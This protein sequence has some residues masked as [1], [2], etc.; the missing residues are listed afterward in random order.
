MKISPTISINKNYHSHQW[1]LASKCKW[2]LP[3]L[4]SSR[5]CHPQ[6]D[7]WGAGEMQEAATCH[8]SRWKRNQDLAP[9]SWG[10]WG[11]PGGASGKEPACQCKRHKRSGFLSWVQKILLRKKWQP[12][13]YSCLE[14]PWIEEPGR[15]QSIR[16]HRVGHNWSNLVQHS[17]QLRYIWKEGIQ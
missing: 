17:T 13:Q 7:C 11:F 16:S 14:N 2:G 3:K 12:F 10:A 4:W 1:F 5:C 8:S 6:G 15:L 9:E